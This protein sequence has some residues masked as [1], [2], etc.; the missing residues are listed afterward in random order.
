[1]LPVWEV[2]AACGS[3]GEMDRNW[4][5]E[6]LDAESTSRIS[7]A[8][9]GLGGTA[10][11]TREAICRSAEMDLAAERSWASWADREDFCATTAA[12]AALVR[13]SAAERGLHRPK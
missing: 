1:M 6:D 4:K 9:A 13:A 10:L 8:S 11:V 5:P 3:P 2:A 7:C 12:C